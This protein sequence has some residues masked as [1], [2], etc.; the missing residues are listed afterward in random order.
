[1]VWD[2]GKAMRKK[3][4]FESA[5][6]MDFEYRLRARAMRHLAARY[7][8]DGAELAR[9]SVVTSDSELLEQI[10]A[11]GVGEREEVAAAHLRCMVKARSELVAE[12]GDPTPNRL[13]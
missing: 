13:G 6:L 11:L 9:A 2:L 4:E 10:V 3:E 7:G 1:M 5:R 8:L 12:R